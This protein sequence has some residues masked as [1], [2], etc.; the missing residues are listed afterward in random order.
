M[1]FGSSNLFAEAGSSGLS[2]GACLGED[3]RTYNE[4][5]ANK[6]SALN[7][8]F[9]CSDS[10]SRIKD[11]VKV[12]S[13][14]HAVGLLTS[15]KNNVKEMPGI[16]LDQHLKDSFV[17]A[18]V[19][20]GDSALSAM[21]ACA[22]EEHEIQAACDSNR[23]NALFKKYFN[24]RS[25]E[26]SCRIDENNPDVFHFSGHLKKDNGLAFCRP[27]KSSMVGFE[28]DY[29]DI[30]SL[31]DSFNG[32]KVFL[33]IIASC[34]S[35]TYAKALVD[36]KVATMAI[37]S[38]SAV[39]DTE[40]VN[41]VSKF[42]DELIKDGKLPDVDLRNSVQKAFAIA[43]KSVVKSRCPMC[44]YPEVARVKK[45]ED[46]GDNIMGGSDEMSRLKQGKLGLSNAYEPS[47]IRS[48]C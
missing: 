15:H 24:V 22:E 6:G 31:I 4:P 42:Y 40:T 47:P 14:N 17:K 10:I 3:E 8:L 34:H 5:K 44:I 11:V 9:L 48:K 33:A 35:A 37:G 23:G 45:V 36:A 41:F 25:E 1:A 13:K 26:V 46:I 29:M 2:S 38:T 20:G 21:L 18:Y 7:I 30:D 27:D 19:A 16:D 32:K 39:N 28:S 43:M 12:Q